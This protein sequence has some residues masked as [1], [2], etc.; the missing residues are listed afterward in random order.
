MKRPEEGGRGTGGLGSG[1]VGGQE[2]PL[3]GLSGG[4][5]VSHLALTHLYRRSSQVTSGGLIPAGR[6]LLSSGDLVE[7]GWW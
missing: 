5:G 6:E 1:A 2:T 7:L 4:A 3:S